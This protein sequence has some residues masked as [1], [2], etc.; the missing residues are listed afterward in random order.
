MRRLLTFAVVA[1]VI[2]VA[3][4]A[5]IDVL[6]DS[7]PRPGED[8][9]A[10]ETTGFQPLPF[11]P[12]LATWEGH[13]RRTVRLSRVVGAG[14]E[15]IR[16]LDPGSYTLTVRIELPHSADVDVWFES[17]TGDTIDLLGREHLRDC[18]RLKDRDLCVTRVDVLQDEAEGWRLLA[19][20][21]FRGPTVMHLR[22]RFTKT[23]PP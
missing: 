20:K 21:I 3:G 5:A 8:R 14:W 12:S 10:R 6:R 17:A 13:H 22:I 19:R 9:Q 4:A 15:E 2:G 7:S 16:R 11:P 1:G 18:R 23:G